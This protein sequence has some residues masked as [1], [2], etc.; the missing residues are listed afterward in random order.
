MLSRMR[1]FDVLRAH[2]EAR[3]K[4]LGVTSHKKLRA[5]VG[6]SGPVVS[7]GT[8]GRWR[9]GKGAQSFD[10]LDI[11]AQNLGVKPWE[12]LLPD[13]EVKPPTLSHPAVL[14]AREFDACKLPDGSEKLELYARLLSLIHDAEAPSAP[15]RPQPAPAPTVPHPHAAEKHGG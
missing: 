12:L 4:A 13:D 14:L 1:S 7:N 3:L 11:L 9:A 6:A 2:F 10:Q 15:Q 8:F 5:V